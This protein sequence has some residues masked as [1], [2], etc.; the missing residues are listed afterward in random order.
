MLSLMVV[1]FVLIRASNASFLL[2]CLALP[3]LIPTS[4]NIAD[5]KT[6]VPCS[7]SKA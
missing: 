7:A 1:D 6:G 4:L 5:F 2:T 3:F